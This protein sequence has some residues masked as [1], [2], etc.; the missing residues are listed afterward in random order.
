MGAV[1][2]GAILGPLPEPGAEAEDVDGLLAAYHGLPLPLLVSGNMV[3]DALKYKTN[4]ISQ[5]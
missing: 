2:V 1:W 5:K 3:N 4:Y